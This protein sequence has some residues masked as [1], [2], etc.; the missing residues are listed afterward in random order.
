[1][2][3]IANATNGL[4]FGPYEA[5]S[6]FLSI[7]GH[8]Y[9]M[10]YFRIDAMPYLAVIRLLQGGTIQIVDATQHN[11]ALPDSIRFG[12]TTFALVFNRAI[13]EYDLKVASWQTPE[14]KRAAMSSAH[15]KL[16]QRI[17]R[18]A[19]VFGH[20]GPVKMGE[21]IQWEVHRNFT[22]D[23]KPNQLLKGEVC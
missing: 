14:M 5:V 1:M 4:A 8:N 6:M 7:H 11:K 9:S 21:Q 17:R 19:Q 23:D 22:L 15:K 10:G 2:L 16:V 13:G 3:R 18:L 12:V 20:S